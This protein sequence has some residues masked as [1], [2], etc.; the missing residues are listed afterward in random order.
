M[1]V[2]DQAPIPDPELRKK[3]RRAV[4]KYGLARLALFVV[5]TIVIQTVAVVIDAPIPLV[6]TALLALFVALPLSM[7]I[8]SQWR[9]EATQ[10][11]GEY[12]QQR[13]EHKAWVQRELSG[14]GDSED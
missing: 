11:I 4:V 3:S 10:S 6:F 12:S 14:R 1:P 7:L 8:F 5:L 9:M 2:D 13:K